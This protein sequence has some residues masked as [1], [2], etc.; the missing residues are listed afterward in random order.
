MD[1]PVESRSTSAY[2]ATL[3]HKINHSFLPN[4]RFCDFAHPRFGRILAV[5]ATSDLRKG[6]EILCNYGYNL[7]DCPRW[8]KEAH[9]AFF[10]DEQAATTVCDRLLRR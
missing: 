3:A 10:F 4:A 7:S 6:D 5:R 8:Y 1:I 9:D 2:S